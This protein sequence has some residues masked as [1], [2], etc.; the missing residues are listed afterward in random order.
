MKATLTFTLPE[1]SEEFEIAVSAGRAY[2][3]LHSIANQVFRP[4][5]KHGYSEE[6]LDKLNDN[7]DVNRAIELL[8]E[9]F[10]QILNEHKIEI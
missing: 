8:E 7:D 6:E 5:R 3:A 2:S 4:A 9:K 10:W 1:E